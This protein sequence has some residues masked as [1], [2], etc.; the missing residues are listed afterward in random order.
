MA[1]EILGGMFHG[2]SP[3]YMPLKTPAF[4][5]P[6]QVTLIAQELGVLTLS[7]ARFLLWLLVGVPVHRAPLRRFHSVAFRRYLK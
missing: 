5:L 7:S 6:G 3:E 2:V 4:W 1:L